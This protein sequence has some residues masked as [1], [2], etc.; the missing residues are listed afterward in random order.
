M[1][2]NASVQLHEREGCDLRTVFGPLNI[3]PSARAPPLFRRW[4]SNT[5]VVQLVTFLTKHQLSTGVH[6]SSLSV[7]SPLDCLACCHCW[8]SAALRVRC[9]AHSLSRHDRELEE[10]GCAFGLSGR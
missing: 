10:V 8:P 1:G 4:L 9:V 6:N 2:A 3:A 7:D 5:T